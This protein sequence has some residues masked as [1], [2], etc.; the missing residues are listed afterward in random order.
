MQQAGSD[1]WKMTADGSKSFYIKQYDFHIMTW[2]N[3]RA[4]LESPDKGSLQTAVLLGLI[5]IPLTLY[6][7]W[8]GRTILDGSV[9]VAVGVGF[10]VGYLYYTRP[11]D[12]H[13]AGLIA[14]F[15]AS[16]GGIVVLGREIA[17]R[18]SSASSVNTVELAAIP[19][20]LV[21]LSLCLAGTVVV[22][23]MVGSWIAKI[24]VQP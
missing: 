2:S 6:I 23:A 22:F 10:A 19:F 13:W 14:G 9:L 21:L 1:R 24:R 20:V 12:S 7:S 3:S 15:V 5:S 4:I 18:T 16:V 11:V 17:I 8:R